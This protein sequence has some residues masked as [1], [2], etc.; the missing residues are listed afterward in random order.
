MPRIMRLWF[1]RNA[2]FERLQYPLIVL[3]LL[4]AVLIV[5]S[6]ANPLTTRLG[7][8]SGMYAY[9]GSHLLHG[10]T[11]YLTAWE[12]KPPAIFFINAAGLWLGG[13]TRWG[14]WAVEFLFLLA[15][16]LTAFEALR[17]FFGV[18]PALLACLLW[19]PGLSLVLEGGNFTEEYSLLFSFL[20]LLLFSRLL[21]DPES[22]RLH[23]AL[24]VV[25]GC[26]LLTRP[27]NAGVPV[28]IILTE[29]VLVALRRR[30]SAQTLRG[31]V[32]AGVGFLVPVAASAG[33][34]ASRNALQAALDAGF[35]YNFSYG[36]QVDFA[37]AFISGVHNLGFVAG[38]GLVGMW[39]AF[40][41]LLGQ[42][43]SRTIDP[44][45]L[46]LGLDFVA[47]VVLSGLSGLNYPHYFMCWLPWIS[48]AGAL[49]F[50]RLFAS[51]TAW[52]QRFSL[53]VLLA[54]ILALAL[55]SVNTLAVYAGAFGR[56]AARRPDAV[57]S[58]LLPQYVNEHTQPGQTVLVWG[59]EAGVNFLA[60]RDSPTAHFQY[61]IL[62][63]SPITDRISTEFYQDLTSHPPAMILDGSLGDSGGDLVPLST[64]NPVA[65]SAAHHQYAPRYLQEFFDFVHANYVFRTTVARVPVYYLNR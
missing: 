17:R 25:F 49:L 20:A 3:L 56:L 55:A 32:A 57:R 46:W 43:K 62:V 23:A 44:L 45:L 47:E 10:K 6:Q 11:P 34:F 38:I 15:A 18:W 65:W 58:E 42:L 27:N 41:R 30:S 4:L 51:S 26:S 14:I 64:P 5:L 33:Y 8:D 63:P 50:E 9:V 21:G 36:G 28:T 24:G 16:V 61:G 60:G 35:I 29:L 7:R 13:G 12:H 37:A 19:L 31:L 22:L 1:D 54:A 40:E 59:G 48:V 53:P 52:F 2:S 39:V